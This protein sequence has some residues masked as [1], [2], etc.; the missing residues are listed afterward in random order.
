MN[1][2]WLC[3][4]ALERPVFQPKLLQLQQNLSDLRS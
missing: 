2:G 1:G 3:R 4:R